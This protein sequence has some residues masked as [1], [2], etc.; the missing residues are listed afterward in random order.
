MLCLVW[1]PVLIFAQDSIPGKFFASG[2]PV[3]RVF[4]NFHTGISGTNTNSAFELERAYLG[5]EMGLG[6]GFDAKIVLDVGSPDD[7]SEFSKIRRYAYFKN[8]AI[9]YKYKFLE[10]DFGLID[11][12]HFKL[13]ESFW[14]HRYI[15]KSFADRYRF[16][17]SADLGLG[18]VFDID[19]RL[20]IDFTVSNGEG[21]SNLQRDD[22]LKTGLGIESELFKGFFIRVYS[23]MM[24]NEIAESAGVVFAG[25]KYKDVV[26]VGAE[27]N[28]LFNENYNENFN[29]SGYSA[30]GSCNLPYNLELFARYDFVRSNIPVNED[31]PWDLSNDGSSLVGGLQYS[32]VKKLKVALSYRDWYPYAKNLDNKA[33]IYLY[34]EFKY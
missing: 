16:G 33:Y 1:N 22:I 24:L 6:K 17:P 21:Y 11:M 3:L 7:V 5:Y 28:W 26:T 18:L 10:V 27:Y 15:E 8:A 13:Q 4:S 20:K 29:R 14:G 34:V 2:K 19:P 25:Y 23:D 12:Q 9:S 32:P 30:Y 31:L